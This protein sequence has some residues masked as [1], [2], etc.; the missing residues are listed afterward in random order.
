MEVVSIP[1][2]CL[3][4]SDHRLCESQFYGPGCSA[5][6]MLLLRRSTF[7]VLINVEQGARLCL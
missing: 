5:A 3:S 6:M 4:Q 1:A 7:I 2:P